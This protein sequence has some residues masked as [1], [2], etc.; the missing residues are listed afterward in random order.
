MSW[1]ACNIKQRI[2]E[3]WARMTQSHICI[4]YVDF[5]LGVKHQMS[6]FSLQPRC[7]FADLE[8]ETAK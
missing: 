6:L 1:R 3:K 4:I 8:G 7:W 5:N 2:Y